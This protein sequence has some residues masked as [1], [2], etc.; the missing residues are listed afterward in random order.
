MAAA[1]AGAADEIHLHYLNHP[2]VEAL[3]LSDAEIIAVALP[4]CPRGRK[5]RLQR[6][7]I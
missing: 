6:P 1:S 3:A 7:P 2:D 5:Y 4:P